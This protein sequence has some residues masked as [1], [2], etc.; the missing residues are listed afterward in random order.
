MYGPR[1]DHRC[2]ALQ[3]RKEMPRMFRSMIEMVV[4]V[5]MR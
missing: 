4:G 2:D 3:P 5:E 1:A